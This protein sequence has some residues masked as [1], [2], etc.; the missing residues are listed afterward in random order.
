M[1]GSAPEKFTYF[2]LIQ[3]NDND[4]NKRVL[5]ASSETEVF[6][7]LQDLNEDG[8]LP[9]LVVYKAETI[10]NLTKWKK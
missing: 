1:L 4:E 10:L 5:R 2:I 9:K 7:M 6:G 3:E 8:D